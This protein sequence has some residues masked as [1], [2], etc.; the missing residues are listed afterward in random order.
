MITVYLLDDHEVVR[1][2][3]HDLLEAEKDIQVVGETG[4]SV[5][6]RRAIPSLRP[7]VMLLDVRLEDG[8]G[9]SVC[10]DVRSIDPTIQALILTSYEDDEAFMSAVLA[11][12]KGY[13]LK[14]VRGSAIVTSVRA[15]AAGAN[16]LDPT[17]T[18]L[19]AE[20]LRPTVRRPEALSAL[21]PQE[22][23]VLDLIADG[24]TNREIA[25][26]LGLAEKT[27]KNYVSRMLAKLGLETRTQA[28]VLA[29]RI[30]DGAPD[31]SSGRRPPR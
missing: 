19:V 5:Q 3:L 1:R 17:V 20:R 25:E 2:G 28:A 12:A 15:I 7:D 10:R 24:I 18:Q 11:G 21:S 31:P 14:Q 22:S 4:S 13:L 29:T 6:A 23:R 26:R 27:I 9:I 16:L 8:S 30:V